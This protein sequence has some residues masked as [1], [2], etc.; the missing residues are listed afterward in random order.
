MG[1]SSLFQS[2]YADLGGGGVGGVAE[3]KEGEAE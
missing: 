3:F 2:E 1:M